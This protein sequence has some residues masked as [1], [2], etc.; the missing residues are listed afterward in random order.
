M[1]FEVPEEV[2][3][4]VVLNRWRLCPQCFYIEAGNAGSAYE[5]ER[6]EGDSWSQR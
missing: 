4:K 6:L 2:G 3:R 5:F 1:I